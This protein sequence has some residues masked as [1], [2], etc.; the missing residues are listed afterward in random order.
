MFSVFKLIGADFV[1]GL[2]NR[3]YSTKRLTNKERNS[4]ILS[5]ELDQVMIGLCLGDLCVRKHT[6]GINA[7]S[8]FEQGFIHEAYILHLYDL[9]KDYCGTGPK[10][11]DRLPDFRTGKVYTRITFQTYS[12]PCF[13][14]YYDLFYV[15]KVKRIPNNIGN[16]LTPIG[17]AYW[18]MDDGYKIGSG[19]ILS[20]NS[21]TLSEVELL[22]RVLK[23]NFDLNCSYH[24][25]TKD[26]Y[27]IYIKSDSMD[28]FLSLVT[29][30][31]HS[32]MMYKLAV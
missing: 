9:F 8:Q 27:M 19:F 26:Q 32:S 20:T 25:K 31:F 4:L 14:Y 13:N 15:D 22:I 30:H 11:T 5:T 10:I 24:T 12:L 29:P 18:A 28:K 2:V 21:Y 16:L 6:R 23:E 7:I 1:K 17:L 3:Y